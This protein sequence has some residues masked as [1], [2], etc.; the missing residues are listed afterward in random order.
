M[1]I[2]GQYQSKYS[3]VSFAEFDA[4]RRTNDSFRNR[5][6]KGHHKETSP[7]ERLDIDMIRNFPCSDSLHLLD[8]GVMKTCMLRWIFGEKDYKRKWHTNLTDRV[9]NLL[10]Q[11]QP[12]K[13]CEIHRAI[14]NLKCV[15]KWKGVEFRT[16]LLYVGMVVF[17]DI[18]CKAEYYHFLLLCCAVRICCSSNLYKNQNMI[19]KTMFRS[20]VNMYIELYGVHSIGSNVHLLSHVI[21]DMKCCNVNNIMKIST[22]KYENGLRLLGLNLKQGYLPLEQVARRILET[23]QFAPLIRNH[24]FESNHFTPQVFYPREQGSVTIYSKIQISPDVVLSSRR[25]GDSWFLTK[26]DEIVKMEFITKE[27]SKFEIMGRV[28]EEKDNF[29]QNPISSTK[30]KIFLSNGKKSEELKTFNL[31]SIEAK[32]VCLPYNDQFVFMPL[33][34]SS[35]SLDNLNNKN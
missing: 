30:L 7:L 2:I 8:L 22:Y 11:C 5:I 28:V 12:Y 17:K 29:F 25:F 23:M 35:E 1:H 6:E 33:I 15:R 18:L 34:H 19:A 3:K 13:P 4:E 32:M 21:E 9:S 31:N 26:S 14:R 24:L 16:I 10:V 20:Y 27:N